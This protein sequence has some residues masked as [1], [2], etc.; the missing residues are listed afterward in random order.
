MNRPLKDV[1]NEA[2][3]IVRGQTQDNYTSWGKGE[4][5][6]SIFTF[7]NFT[8]TEVLKGDLKETKI[9]LR[10]PGG[11]KDGI[12][13]HVPGAAGF[14][15]GE[16]IVVLLSPKNQDDG[17][18][19]VPGL[20]TG[21]YL[22]TERDGK[23]FL[24]NSM[25]GGA[26]YDPQKAAGTLSYNSMLPYDAFK[27]LARGEPVPEAQLKQYEPSKAPPAKGAFESGHVHSHM[28]PP[29]VTPKAAPSAAA[30][31][32]I[33]EE[34]SSLWMPIS[35]GALLTAMAYFIYRMINKGGKG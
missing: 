27:K 5:S 8:I 11:A 7:T 18:Y 25:G 6:R 14:A 34:R 24:E 35:F 33:E 13:M 32:P 23:T 12:E 10:Q 29:K 9:V 26:F 16:D 3:Y 30:V 1:V 20:V 21:K 28:P 4:L 15:R 19:D 22:V 2:V 31:A 17:S